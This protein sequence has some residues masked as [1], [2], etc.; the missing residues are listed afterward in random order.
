MSTL[1]YSPRWR[2]IEALLFMTPEGLTAREVGE[3]LGCSTQAAGREL[4]AF[5]TARGQEGGVQVI[6]LAGR[7]T[8]ATCDDLASQIDSF[9]SDAAP[10]A[11]LSKAALETLAVVAYAQPVTRNEVEELRG[12][13][14][15]R[16]LETLLSH[17]LIRV[18]GRRKATGSPLLFRTTDAFLR[19]FGLGALSEL[20]SLSELDALAAPS[21]R[22]E[23]Q[24]EHE[25][26]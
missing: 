16:S 17:G 14:S 4:R 15:D 26:E 9:M 8:L 19:L 10:V 25:T 23:G 24:N 2:L 7:Y 5:A 11:R 12:V 22:E 18:A 20:P 3:A 21:V 6:E 1:T 13:R